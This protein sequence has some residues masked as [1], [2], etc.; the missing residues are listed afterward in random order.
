MGQ[1]VEVP[2]EARGGAVVYVGFSALDFHTLYHYKSMF[3]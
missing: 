3:V 1:G 2:K